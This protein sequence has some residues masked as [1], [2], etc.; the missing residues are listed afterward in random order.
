MGEDGITYIMDGVGAITSR[1]RRGCKPH[2]K[3]G[4]IK[5]VCAFWNSASWEEVSSI[6]AHE[7]MHVKQ[8]YDSGY[9]YPG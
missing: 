9:L 2:F 5:I 6:L 7:L 4:Y 1:P 3:P 8:A